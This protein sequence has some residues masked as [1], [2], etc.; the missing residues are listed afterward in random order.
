MQVTDTTGYSGLSGGIIIH[1]GGEDIIQKGLCWSTETNPVII[2]NPNKTYDGIGTDNFTRKITGLQPN[3]LYYVRAYA[4]NKIGTAYGEEMTI[5]THALPTLTATTPATDII[6]TTAVSGGNITDDGRTPIISRGICWSRYSN[7]T[8]GL[9]TKIIEED[10]PGTGIFTM[11]MTGLT[12][13]T[14]YYVRA[15]AT[16]SVGTNY[17]S[18]VYFTTNP[19]MLPTLSTKPVS[20]IKSRE[21][22]CGGEIIDDGG[23]PLMVRGIC[24]DTIPEPTADLSSKTND[25][26]IGVGEYFNALAGLI[27]HTKY[28][29]RAFATNSLGTAYGE[30]VSFMTECV[31]PELSTVTLSD[32]TMES[33]E[34]SATIT[35]DGGAPVTECGIYWNTA[36]TIAV[37][38]V[39]TI[40]DADNDKHIT[41]LIENLVPATKYYVWAYATNKIGRSYSHT[42][43]ELNT[44]GLPTVITNLPLEVTDTSAVCGGNIT[45]EGG[46]PVI[47]RGVCWSLDTT[48]DLSDNYTEHNTGGPGNY[49]CDIDSLKQGTKYY[50]RAFA[51]NAMGTSYGNLDSLQTLAVPTLTT[52]AA[53]D[54]TNNSAVS[55]GEITDDGGVPV[56]AR[57]VCWSTTNI[58]TVDSTKTVDGTGIGEFTSNMTNLHR[59]TKYY[60][61]AYATNSVGTG[62]GQLDSLVTLPQ[63]PVV[64]NVIMGNMVDGSADGTA[65]VTDDGGVEVT[66]RGLCLSTKGEP[67]VF[68]Q[69]IPVGS[70]IG[71]FT[72]TMSGLVEGPTYYIRAYATNSGGTAYSEEILSFKICPSEFEVIHAAGF[73]GAPETKTVTYHSVSTMISGAPR[74]WLTQ[75]LGADSI[76]N[77]VN[78]SR[79]ESSGWYFQFNRSQGY[80][81]DGTTRTPSLSPWITGISEHKDWEP[82]NDPCRLLLGLGWR[83]PTS[84]E[85]TSADGAP[86]N[87]KTPED[88]YNSVLKLHKAGNLTTGGTLSSRGTEGNYWSSNRYIPNYSFGYRYSIGGTV[89]YALKATAYPVRCLR[90]TL[91]ISL[92]AISNVE[93]VPGTMTDTTVTCTASVTMSGGSEITERGIC[94]NKSGTPSIS[95]NKIVSGKG[96]G[97]YTTILRDLDES[98][99]YYVRAY[100]I[101]T[102]G[103]SYSKEVTSFKICPSEFEVIHAAGF[104]GAPETKTVT[105]HSVST[106]ISGAPRCWLTQNLGADSIANSVNDSRMESSGCISSLTVVRAISTTELHVPQVFHRGLQV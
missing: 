80:K 87:W 98:P 73:N 17:G 83:L 86:Q 78:D 68:D 24:W 55:G 32:I 1:D 100:A 6:A 67:T 9:T 58:P 35:F 72:G 79:M 43:V 47:A 84:S 30:E 38:A 28:Y 70:G 59:V 52:T 77:S 63:L 5:L 49:S 25:A 45:D 29:V 74:C 65:E 69:I 11:R 104:N 96:L 75:N 40:P 91:E 46:I 3:T 97:L 12:P 57:G 76:A 26:S 53:S 10:N 54:I 42:P 51:T 56:I 13:E 37:P 39:N 4:V 8:I 2:D 71:E 27:P 85:W 105:Y 99:T 62:Y 22:L 66:E 36:D 92:P 88:A 94:W 89:N 106:M 61:R 90:D 34:S 50:I 16:N 20:E 64:S 102:K 19:I 31:S 15:F 14:K 95:D 60:F 41:V 21:A 23:V 7:P 101:N 33:A 82:S 93:I 18:Q 103:I 48:P 81:H 44:P